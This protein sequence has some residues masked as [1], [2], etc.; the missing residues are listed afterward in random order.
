MLHFIGLLYIFHNLKAF[1]QLS[2]VGDITTTN[3]FFSLQAMLL[4]ISKI[5]FSMLMLE[6]LPRIF[7]LLWIDE[8]ENHKYIITNSFCILYNFW[9]F[10]LNI[11]SIFRWHLVKVFLI[12]VE[13]IHIPLYTVILFKDG[14]RKCS[15]IILFGTNY[16]SCRYE[17]GRLI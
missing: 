16:L 1:D 10:A 13:E 8:I 7:K 12:L 4:F 5:N 6:I 14:Q 15:Y 2:L 17:I 9:L 11:F 3:R